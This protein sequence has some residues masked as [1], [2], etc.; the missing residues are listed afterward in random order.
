MVICSYYIQTSSFYL[1]ERILLIEG[2]QA[3]GA[4]TISSAGPE[5]GDRVNRNG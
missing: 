3:D 2:V 1:D 4:V 5:T